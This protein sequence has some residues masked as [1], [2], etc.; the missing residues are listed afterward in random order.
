MQWKGRVE[1]T[2]V[3]GIALLVC[4]T[5]CASSMM[6]PVAMEPAPAEGRALV[7]FLRPSHFGGA[8]QFG[9]WDSDTFVGVLSAG[10]YIQYS[11]APGEHI[12]LA[13]AENWSYV[14]ADLEAGKQ[15]YIIA[16]VFP[17]F[18]KARVAFDPVRK[19]DP[20]TDDE[21]AGWLEKLTPT[22]VIPE[23]REAYT[24]PRVEQV[25]EAVAAF[26]AGEVQYEELAADDY[27]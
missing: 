8:I 25:R 13:R 7:T 6:H 16:K 5:G 3:L 24:T 23:K 19:D 26:K 14:H 17:G 15:Y 12:F 18:W 22:T 9:V 11:A 20:E 10:S 2:L 4:L 21:I 1:G 27:R